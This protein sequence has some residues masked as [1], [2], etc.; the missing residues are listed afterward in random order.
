MMSFGTAF[1]A[2]GSF[3]YNYGA[4]FGT[5][6]NSNSFANIAVGQGDAAQGSQQ[7]VLFNDYN[8]ADHGNNAE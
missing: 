6:L 2:D 4:P 3:V 7:L 5:P 8:N 1:T